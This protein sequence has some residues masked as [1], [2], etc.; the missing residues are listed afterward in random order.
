MSIAASLSDR[1]DSD[2]VE[3]GVGG[4]GVGNGGGSAAGSGGSGGGGAH[5]KDRSTTPLSMGSGQGQT[6]EERPVVV[7]KL[8]PTPTARL[9]RTHDKVYDAT[10][11][12]VRAVMILSQGNSL[13]R[14]ILFI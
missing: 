10:T 1:S 8:E 4:C 7:K 6:T 3:G 14:I 9:D 5:N 13:S 2:S 11:S 12:V